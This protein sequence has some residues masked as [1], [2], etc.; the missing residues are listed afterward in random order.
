MNKSKLTAVLFFFLLITAF[1]CKAQNRPPDD[2]REK[3]EAQ[4]AT[5]INEQLQLTPEE[6]QKFWPLYNQYN[7][8]KGE[9]TEAFFKDIRRFRPNDDAMTDKD[10]SELADNYI[11]HAQKMLDIQ[12]EY[13]QKFK[14]VLPPKKLLKLYNVEREFQRM[15][16]KRL[17][18]HKMGRP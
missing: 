2:Q 7:N 17:G 5:F 12:K 3:I 15:L 8:S 1:V 14:E 4:K 11:R 6:A 16:L 13:H 9:L 10:A 18:E